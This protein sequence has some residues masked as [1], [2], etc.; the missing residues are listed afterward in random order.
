MHGLL[1]SADGRTEL[2]GPLRLYKSDRRDA[3][4][5]PIG[6]GRAELHWSALDSEHASAGYSY[7]RDLSPAG[8]AI[9]P[10]PG[11]APPP[12]GV[13]PAELRIAELRV[14]CLVETRRAPSVEGETYGVHLIAG[15]EG[16]D[17]ID[18][19]LRERLP[20]L[21][22]RHE[23]DTKAL[24]AL[25]VKSG[26]LSLRAAKTSFQA[27]QKCQVRDSFACD[28]VYRAADGTLLGHGSA[29]RIYSRTWIL[30]QLATIGGHP[31]SAECRAMLY[32]M[33][34]SVPTLYDGK[35]ASAMAYFDLDL[36]W[37]DL[38]FKNFIRWIGNTKLACI[39]AFDRF[40]REA[41]PE[42]YE[43]PEGYSVRIA[44]ETEMVQCAALVRAQLPEITANAFDTHP[45]E[46]RR[47]PV[48]RNDR[49]RE[50]LVLMHG[51]E[52]AGLA[53]CETGAPNLSL[54]NIVNMAQLYVRR[55][56]RAPSSRA[57]RALIAAARAF[58]AARRIETPLV[59]APAGTVD[60][61]AEPGTHWAESMGCMVMAGRG[62]SQWENYCRFQF[63][64][65]WGRKSSSTGDAKP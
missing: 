23:V 46:L 43:P 56:P 65:R 19:Y 36:R 12:S 50:V 17:L 6:E 14:P 7:V 11:S 28:R 49:G 32:S 4:R 24:R 15:G 58:Y 31:E 44:R 30:H 25:M 51:E 5:Q 16:V 59:I 34:T 60:H 1:R 64:K 29:T 37:H 3:W 42:P 47:V 27:W 35:R 55:G 13:F 10:A 40:E 62:I 57:Q 21:V 38:F 41:P 8:A 26:Y 39:F 18:V 9:V 20:R 63:G 53:L 2:C 33:L 52:L 22:P 61:D 48:R 45:G 54:F